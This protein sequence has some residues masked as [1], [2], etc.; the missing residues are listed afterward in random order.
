MLQT[1]HALEGQFARFLPKASDANTI[2]NYIMDIAKVQRL[3]RDYQRAF[4]D[5]LVEAL[6]GPEHH[7]VFA[8]E[9]RLGIAKARQMPNFKNVHPCINTVKEG[10]TNSK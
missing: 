4:Q 2:A 1:H 9:H 6:T 10:M 5:M 8:K 7:S 3:R